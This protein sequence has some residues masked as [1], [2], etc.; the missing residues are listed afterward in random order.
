MT[1]NSI[2]QFYKYIA[3]NVHSMFVIEFL[4]CL[5]CNKV[6]VCKKGLAWLIANLNHPPTMM[7]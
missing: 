6:F 1:N 4:R 3:N 2:T 5:V 7:C